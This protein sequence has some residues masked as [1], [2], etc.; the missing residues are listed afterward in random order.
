M[1][2]EDLKHKWKRLSVNAD[3]IDTRYITSEIVRGRVESTQRRL[4]HSYYRN[5]A[6]ALLVIA[7]APLLVTVLEFETWV[8]VCYGVFGFVMGVLN[9][10]LGV[11]I[12]N[13]PII[14]LPVVEAMRRVER[15]R[16]Y[17][18]RLEAFG[19]CIGAMVVVSMF[20]QAFGKSDVSMVWAMVIGLAIGLPIGIAKFLRARAIAR[21]L[22]DQLNSCL[23]PVDK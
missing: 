4:A 2:L 15:V 19:I 1:E 21:D 8:A 11:H 12:A 13:S 16:R 23:E 22:N 7:I 10:F 17:M 3:H 20:A 5:A 18:A 9:L 6:F 14:S